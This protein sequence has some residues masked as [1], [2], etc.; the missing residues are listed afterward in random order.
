MSPETVNEAIGEG[1]FD[2]STNRGWRDE[3]GVALL[4]AILIVSMLL[5][6]GILS[7]NLATQEIQSTRAANDE[8]VLRH[9]AK[10]GVDLVM[11][12]FHDPSS[13]PPGASGALFIKRHDLPES[14]S[15][16]FDAQGR[17]QFTGTA[18][19]PDLSVDA[20]RSE[21]D[22]LL[23]DPVAGWFRALRPLGRISKLRLYGPARPGLLCTVD[24]TA[25]KAGVSRTQSV[26]LG[27]RTIPPLRAGAQVGGEGTSRTVAPPGRPLPLSVHWG[28]LKVKGDA[29]LGRR[30]EIPVKTTLASVTGRSYADMMDREDRWLGRIQ[31]PASRWTNGTTRFSRTLLVFLAPIMSWGA[32]GCCTKTGSCNRATDGHRTTCSDPRR[33]E[34]IRAW[35]SWMPWISSPRLRTIWAS[36]R[37]RPTMQ[38]GSLSSTPMCPGSLLAWGNRFPP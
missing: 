25:E 36:S 3:Q 4:A 10:A 21:D 17:S 37:S 9:L 35:C 1:R 2:M 31:S 7:L 14:G 30:E 19:R 38:R 32:T 33:W 22:R 26:Q 8:A 6:L 20:A 29:V 11:Q 23:N 15:S 27:A 12:W 34:T 18:D 13:A 28:D 24:I 5:S 16:F